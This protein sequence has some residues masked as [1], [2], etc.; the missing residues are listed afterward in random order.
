[1]GITRISN[2]PYDILFDGL[3]RKSPEIWDD[4]HQSF[5]R[6]AHPVPIHSHN[7]YER[8]IP[9]FEAIGSGCISVEADIHLRKS[10]LLVGHSSLSLRSGKTLQSMYL[11]PLQRMIEAQN[12]GRTG[13][14]RGLFDTAPEQTLT[15]LIDFKTNGAET[16]PVLNAQLESL[17]KLDYL[18]YWN[19]TERVMRPLTIVATGNA[20]FESILAMNETRRDIFWDAKLERL[21]SKED[22]FETNPP[23]YRFNISNSYFASTRF[24][25]AILFRE[26][27]GKEK[28]AMSLAERDR[29]STQIEQA[30]SRGLLARYWDT[31]ADPPNVRDIAWR[32]LV[33][34][35]VGIL[36][37]DD[38]GIV[39]ARA[40]GWGQ[41]DH[42]DL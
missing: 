4:N 37:M 38:M 29:K 20:P 40:K 34:K 31:P 15:L 24:G 7:D 30:A 35:K 5:L 32:V 21:L 42:E 33:Q 22:N 6:S 23:T 14:W 3:T 18:T 25:N 1:M 8:N 41:L 11:K 10:D 19:G 9:L 13:G 2:D 39:R 16:F 27:E 12:S 36:N 17:R 26:N 28:D